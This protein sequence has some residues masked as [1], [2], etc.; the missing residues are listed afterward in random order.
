M[1]LYHYT[2]RHAAEK[3]GESGHLLPAIRLASRP[4]R[5]KLMRD[6]IGRMTG[7]VVWLTTQESPTRWSLGL[8]SFSLCCDRTE[9]RYRVTEERVLIESWHDKRIDWPQRV[10]SELESLPGCLPL[11]WWIS[12]GP[13]AVELVSARVRQAVSQ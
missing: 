12:R 13:V 8:T 4:D 10:V 7:Q 11:G 2:C 6:S 3:I 9:I 1:P 5:I